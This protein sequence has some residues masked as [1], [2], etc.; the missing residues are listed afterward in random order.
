MFDRLFRNIPLDVFEKAVLDPGSTTPEAPGEVICQQPPQNTP[1]PNPLEGLSVDKKVAQGLV[2]AILQELEN[3]PGIMGRLNTLPGRPLRGQSDRRLYKLLVAAHVLHTAIEEL[4]GDYYFPIGYRILRI[5]FIVQGVDVAA[6]SQGTNLNV[7][8]VYLAV[9]QSLGYW[10]AVTP[11]EFQAPLA[12]EIPLL[13]IFLDSDGSPTIEPLGTTSGF[14]SST[15]HGPSGDASIHIDCDN[16]LFVDRFFEEDRLPVQPG[17]FDLITLLTHEIGHALG[18][19]HPAQETEICIMSKGQAPKFVKR[20]LFPF[21][22]LEVQRLHGAVRLAEPVKASLAET[23]EL[24]E[25]SPGVQLSRDASGIVLFGPM[26][27]RALLEFLVPAQGRLVNALRLKFTALTRNIFVN[28]VA[29][30]DGDLPIQGFAHG[31]RNVGDEGLTGRPW[32][33]QLG[34]QPRRKMQNDLRVQMEI[35]LTAREGDASEF[36]VIQIQEVAAEILLPPP[37]INAGLIFGVN[38]NGDWRSKALCPRL[39]V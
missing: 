19:D 20:Q 4:A 39:S 7:E 23:G 24:V 25:A 31:G 26:E 17:P 13:R 21:D 34:F 5:P 15:P 14:I 11:L 3:Q 16:E 28:R 35:I 33:L 2:K 8:K 32:D 30:F 18:L 22:I 12:S 37:G 6:A 10:S 9:R 29:T 38:W 36:G 27:T 1:N